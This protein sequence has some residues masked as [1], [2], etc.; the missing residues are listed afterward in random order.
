MGVDH[1]HTGCNPV[2]ISLWPVHTGHPDG[3][4]QDV[5]DPVC[6]VT[7]R[8]SDLFR[9]GIF[10]LHRGNLL[11]VMG[12]VECVLKLILEDETNLRKKISWDCILYICNCNL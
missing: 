3:C 1:G 10:R 5:L 11:K 8:D 2:N 9:S 7:P 6:R 12:D 4:L